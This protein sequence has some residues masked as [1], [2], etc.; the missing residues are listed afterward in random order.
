MLRCTRHHHDFVRAH[1]RVCLFGKCKY[2]GAHGMSI[3]LTTHRGRVGQNRIY[4]Y[5]YTV[6][7]VISM[8]KI[9]YVHRI[10]MVLANPTQRL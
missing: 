10:Y 8:P 6:Y 1:L 4:T 2:C 5:I 3:T 9:L 7:L